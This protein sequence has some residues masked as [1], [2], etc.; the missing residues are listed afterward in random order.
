MVPPDG[1]GSFRICLLIL[2]QYTNVTDR[3]TDEQTPHDGIGHAVN[4]ITEKIFCSKMHTIYQ[5]VNLKIVT[6]TTIFARSWQTP[7][8]PAMTTVICTKLTMM[9]VHIKP[10][11]SNTCL[12]TTATC[13]Q[14]THMTTIITN[15][16]TSTV[17]CQNL[18][19]RNLDRQNLDIQNV[20]CLSKCLQATHKL[21]FEL[22]SYLQS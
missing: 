2:I 8:S 21:S 20:E 17:T 9:H 16:I 6:T 14:L 12:S 18:D 15:R 4:S 1:E 11:K 10:K 19:S 7:N 13:R 3:Q 22:K 5:T